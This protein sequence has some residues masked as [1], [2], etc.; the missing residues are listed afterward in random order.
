MLHVYIP[1]N[2]SK[3]SMVV[4]PNIHHLPGFMAVL[5]SQLFLA[6]PHIDSQELPGGVVDQDAA[7]QQSV[8]EVLPLDAIGVMKRGWKTSH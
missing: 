7:L 1:G 4:S 3:K 8:A 2:P 5:R 6:L